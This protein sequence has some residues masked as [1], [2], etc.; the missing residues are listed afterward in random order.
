LTARPSRPALFLAAALAAYLVAAAAIVA[1]AP[2]P[3]RPAKS[4]TEPA[5]ETTLETRRCEI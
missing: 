4:T 5:V 2:T 3:E 1:T